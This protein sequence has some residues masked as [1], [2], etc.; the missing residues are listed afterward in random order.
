VNP[1]TAQSPPRQRTVRVDPYAI[2]D[3]AREQSLT[4]VDAWILHLLAIQAAYRSAEWTGTLL[5]LSDAT[6]ASRKTVAGAVRRLVAK[7]LL[8]MIEPFRQGTDGRVR[9]LCRSRLVFD[10]PRRQNASNDAKSNSV[11]RAEIETGLRPDRDPNATIDA[12]EQGEE[13][14]REVQRHRGAE[15]L[16]EAARC[17]RCGRAVEGHAFDHEPIIEGQTNPILST[18]GAALVKRHFP[19]AEVEADR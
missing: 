11:D 8:E 18:M 12:I 9:V 3:L 7:G 5:D 17:T 10:V 4:A 1:P 15:G 13:G 19:T 16:G 14:D 6:R 2:S